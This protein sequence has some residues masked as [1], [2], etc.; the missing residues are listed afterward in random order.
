MPRAQI[1]MEISG[2][3]A[4]A[5]ASMQRVIDKQREQIDALKEGGAESRRTGTAMQRAFGRTTLNMVRSLGTA[6]G[7]TGGLAGAIVL[8]RKELETL[9]QTQLRASEST[10]TLANA[11]IAFRRNLGATTEAQRLWA[12]Q[13]MKEISKATGVKLS[14]LYVRGTSAISARGPL[15]P[16]LALEAIKASAELVP[17]SL[18]EGTAVVGAV[19]DLAKLLKTKDPEAIL[20]FLGSVSEKSRVTDWGLIGQ[21]VA[22]AITR[23]LQFGRTDER[24]A[25]AL[26]AALGQASADPTGRRTMTGMIGFVDAL[27]KFFGE[28]YEMPTG[29]APEK[30]EYEPPERSKRKPTSA[31]AARNAEIAYQEALEKYDERYAKRLDEWQKQMDERNEAIDRAGELVRGP[32]P[33]DLDAAIRR[34]QEDEDLRREF[35]K[36]WSGQARTGASLRALIAGRETYTDERGNAMR[37]GYDQ[38][39]REIL[40]T[41]SPESRKIYRQKIAQIRGGDVQSAAQSERVLETYKEQLESL[42][43]R[44]AMLGSFQKHF[45]DILHDAGYSWLK[46]KKVEIETWGDIPAKI[47]ELERAAES[48]AGEQ[49]APGADPGYMGIGRM[50]APGPEA[51]VRTLTPEE[52][53]SLRRRMVPEEKREKYDLLVGLAAQLREIYKDSEYKIPEGGPGSQGLTKISPYPQP[54]AAAQPTTTPVIPTDAYGEG[55]SLRPRPTPPG[56][57]E[58]DAD[59]VPPAPAPMTGTTTAPFTIRA[60]GESTTDQLLRELI[61]ETRKQNQ[62]L[63]SQAAQRTQALGNPNRDK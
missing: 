2:D 55:A 4:K 62:L 56:S 18:E 47:Q 26:Y 36:G 9:Q 41:E 48:L 22:P 43:K 31:L 11:Q 15:P 27:E 17:E 19:L 37:V 35:L 20:G 7:V 53:I 29:E 24:Q 59:Q 10:T 58:P 16:E 49:L 54:E 60:A 40:D 3:E 14:D 52:R 13:R 28:R 8:V 1:I 25:A 57:V 44:D 30:P 45:A 42:D 46:V 6:L 38:F 39:K 61:E 21:T 5:I 51:T 50:R 32:M 33:E 12:D 34:L 63:K 23:A